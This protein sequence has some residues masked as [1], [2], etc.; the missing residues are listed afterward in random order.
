MFYITSV[1]YKNNKVRVFDSDTLDL[2]WETFEFVSNYIRNGGVVENIDMNKARKNVAYFTVGFIKPT[3]APRV[4]AGFQYPL[5]NAIEVG[6]IGNLY[7]DKTFCLDDYN[8]SAISISKDIINVKAFGEDYKITCFDVFRID[9]R[10]VFDKDTGD[11]TMEVKE[12]GF[13]ETDLE[14]RLCLGISLTP[15]S[16]YGGQV[17]RK[18]VYLEFSPYGTIFVKSSNTATACKKMRSKGYSRH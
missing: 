16:S 6:G 12:F 14:R 1:D 7:K 18:F 3:D 10:P 15:L 17:R 11:C 4:R 13:M 2:D 8:K 5:Y 9:G